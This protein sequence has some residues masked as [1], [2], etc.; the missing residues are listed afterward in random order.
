MAAIGLQSY[1]L[2]FTFYY[3]RQ[4]FPCLHRKM[5]CWQMMRILPQHRRT[6]RQ[7]IKRLIVCWLGPFTHSNCWEHKVLQ[8]FIWLKINP[9]RKP[10]TVSWAPTMHRSLAT[11]KQQNSWCSFGCDWSTKSNGFNSVSSFILCKKP[12][13]E[14]VGIYYNQISESTT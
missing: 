1:Q 7:R 3:W 5:C 4:H 2:V 11:I 12:F 14:R 6:L 13:S 9:C 8:I 10:Y